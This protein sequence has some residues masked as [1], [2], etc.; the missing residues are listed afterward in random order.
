MPKR[1]L[2]TWQ[3][4]LPHRPDAEA[5]DLQPRPHRQLAVVVD[6]VQAAPLQQPAAVADAVRVGLPRQQ[7][8]VAVDVVRV[9]PAVPR[10]CRPFPVVHLQQQRQ[11]VVVF[12]ADPV[13][14]RHPSL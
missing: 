14:L 3:H 4:W 12:K 13:A 6:V 9:D 1:I 5:A 10:Q 8:V 7:P 11:A 2:P